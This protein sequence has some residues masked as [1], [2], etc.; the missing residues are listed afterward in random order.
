MY[1]VTNMEVILN[2]DV[3]K[4]GKAGAV[5]QVKDGFARN[6]LIPN[7]LAVPVTAAALKRL[8]QERQKKQAQLENLRKEAEELRQ[9][10]G[11]LSLTIASLAKED[12]SLYGGIGAQEIAG[13][14]KEEGFEID[15]EQIS[16][17]QQ[18]KSLGIYEVP[19]KLH[20]EITAKV[21][22]WVVKK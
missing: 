16:L 12:E 9:K 10:L 6:F 15:K 21:K 1:E 5:V 22:L 19:V 8:E 18:I 2:E 13:A 17:E 3:Q 7:G 11:Q 4:L 20:P 14:L